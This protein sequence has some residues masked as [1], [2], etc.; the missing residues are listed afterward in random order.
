MTNEELVVLIQQ[1]RTDLY[2]QLW[3][4]V[5]RYIAQQARRR[6]VQTDGLGGVDVDDLTQSGFFAVVEAV[7][8]FEPGR[9]SFVDILELCLRS[10]FSEAGG[11]KT[12]KRDPMLRY[13]SLDEPI[14]GDDPDGSTF[15]DILKDPCNNYEDAE[16]K[17]YVGQLRRVLDQSISELPIRQNDIL[18]RRFVRGQTLGEVAADLGVSLER[19][20][21]METSALR[22]LNR[23]SRT[24]GLRQFVDQNTNFYARVSPR[25]YNTTRMSA[26]EVLAIHR[27]RFSKLYKQKVV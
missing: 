2:G 4:Q 22:E 6:Y 12:S 21:Q 1:G 15:L 17:I 14:D 18:Y 24:N 16:Q 23:R 5:R 11:Y 8:R 13:K 26:V 7:K 19:V 27:E 10:A 25:T 20:R 3:D 9:G